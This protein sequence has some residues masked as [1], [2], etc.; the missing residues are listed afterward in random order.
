MRPAVSMGRRRAEY[1]RP[2]KGSRFKFRNDKKKGLTILKVTFI[3]TR[4]SE[5]YGSNVKGQS[6]F[7]L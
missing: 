7:N 3:V 1:S 4:S 5:T 6:S 2:D